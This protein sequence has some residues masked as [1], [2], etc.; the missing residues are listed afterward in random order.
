MYWTLSATSLTATKVPN[1]YAAGTMFSTSTAL[2]HWSLETRSELSEG[3]AIRISSLISMTQ[4]QAY[5]TVWR[6]PT[7][8]FRIPKWCSPR[9]VFIQCTIL[10]EVDAIRFLFHTEQGYTKVTQSKMKNKTPYNI[11]FRAPT[12]NFFTITSRVS[13]MQRVAGHAAFYIMCSNLDS[14]ITTHQTCLPNSGTSW[15]QKTFAVNK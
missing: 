12:S 5:L 10:G 4:R 3:T 13:K 8:H 1:L 6:T 9:P 15:T 7:L 14:N 11:V 2:R